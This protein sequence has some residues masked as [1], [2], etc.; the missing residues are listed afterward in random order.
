MSDSAR[1]FKSYYDKTDMPDEGDTS[2][3]E[4]HST[5]VERIRDELFPD[6]ALEEEIAQAINCSPR[7]VQRLNLP[8]KKLGTKRVYDVSGARNIVRR[9]LK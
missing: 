6:G 9:L 3:N 7:Q 4:R 1:Q 2:L 8:Y 5:R